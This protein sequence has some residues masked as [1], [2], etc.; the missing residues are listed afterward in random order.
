MSKQKHVLVV[1]DERALANAL[2]LKLEREGFDVSIFEDGQAALNEV[3]KSKPSL[4]LLDLMMPVMDGFQFLQALKKEK[5][6][7]PVIVATNLSQPEDE[8]RVKKLGA[9]E[10]IVKSSSSLSDIVKKVKAHIG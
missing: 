2:K 7:I 5:I 6:S 1:E 9:V 4:V 3:K 10:F 8:E